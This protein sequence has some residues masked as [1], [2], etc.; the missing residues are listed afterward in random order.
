MPEVFQ[1]LG[2]NATV[3]R[4]AKRIIR[5][6]PGPGE[7]DLNAIV[8]G[9]LV[10][11]LAGVVAAIG[12]PRSLASRSRTSTTWKALKFVLGTIASDSRVWQ[13]TTVKSRNGP[14]SNNASDMKFIAQQ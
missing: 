1:P 8:I 5:R 12:L 7:V 14:P 13:S 2:P 10:E 4:F 3:E 9:P 11:H 6:F